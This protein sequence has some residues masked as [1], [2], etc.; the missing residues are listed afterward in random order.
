MNGF[1]LTLLLLVAA[2]NPATAFAAATAATGA[3]R[4]RATAALIGFLAA[5]AALAAAALGADAI[6][7][8]LELEPETFRVSA[9]IVLAATGVAALVFGPFAWPAE[10]GWKGALFPLAF[11]L[12]A[13]PAALAA[14]V[15]RASDEG[16]AGALTAALIAVAIAAGA[17]VVAAGRS[18]TA[19]DALARLTGALAVALAAGLVVDG[20]RAV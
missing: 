5:A 9:G 6:L 12:L 14:T 20:V 10:E 2:V 13:G 16:V 18:R 19:A 15:S 4:G 17:T 3:L 1:W 8:A 11:P 7:D